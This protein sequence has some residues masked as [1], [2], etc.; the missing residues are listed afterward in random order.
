MREGQKSNAMIV[1]GV[2]LLVI[3]SPLF[4]FYHIFPTINSQIG[5]HQLSSWISVAFGFI[6]FVMIVAGAARKNI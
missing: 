6:G 1:G 3:A 5:P 4:A 2:L